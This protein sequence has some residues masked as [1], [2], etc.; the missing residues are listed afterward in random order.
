MCVSYNKVT[1]TKSHILEFDDTPNRRI[2]LR[3]DGNS[4]EWTIMQTD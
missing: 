3:Q 1:E 4:L 2:H